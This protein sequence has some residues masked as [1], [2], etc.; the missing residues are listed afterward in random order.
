MFSFKSLFSIKQGKL[1]LTLQ[2]ISRLELQNTTL[3]AF[4]ICFPFYAG[5][6]EKKV[7]KWLKD[8]T[9][10]TKLLTTFKIKGYA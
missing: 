9:R 1:C 7:A 8:K 4:V 3:F 6:Q 10:R 5:L 2:N